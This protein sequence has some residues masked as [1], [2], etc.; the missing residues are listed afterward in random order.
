MENLFAVITDIQASSVKIAKIIKVV[1]DIAFQTNL[2]ALNA[3]V[4]AARAGEAGAGFAVVTEEVR[5]LAARCAMAAKETTE[6]IEGPLQKVE[7]AAQIT[8]EASAS[9]APLLEIIGDSSMLQEKIATASA[10]QAKGSIKSASTSISLIRW[11]RDFRPAL[12]TSGKSLAAFRWI[13]TTGWNS[14][15]QPPSPKESHKPEE[16]F[17]KSNRIAPLLLLTVFEARLEP[18]QRQREPPVR[19]GSHIPPC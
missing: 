13:P 12:M 19:P 11:R 3:S 15:Q 16:R 14:T 6:I 2:L 7:S 4:E 10:E 9:L 18:Y 1:D 17:A 5:S 8:R